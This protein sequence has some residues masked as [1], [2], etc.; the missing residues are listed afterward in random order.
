M[1]KEITNPC[2]TQVGTHRNVCLHTLAQVCN[3]CLS[4][5]DVVRE[6]FRGSLLENPAE[7][8]SRERRVPNSQVVFL[9]QNL[10]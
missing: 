6:T 3:L 2:L 1:T 10:W 8:K 4:I 9:F 7:T 5:N